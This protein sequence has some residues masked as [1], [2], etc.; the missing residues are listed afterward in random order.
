MHPPRRDG[1]FEHIRNEKQIASVI[2]RRFRSRDETV[3]YRPNP[4]LTPDLLVTARL[5]IKKP[6][7][8]SWSAVI[9]QMALS[10]EEVFETLAGWLYLNTTAEE[11]RKFFWDG[12][13]NYLAHVH[14]ADIWR[15][16]AGA[17]GAACSVLLKEPVY[18]ELRAF[19]EQ[20][21]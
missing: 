10:Y 17:E 15:F 20:P 4:L 21:S 2:C 14:L 6:F 8:Q 3:T 18:S 13:G 19:L 5:V 1:L 7:F 9:P 16:S 11:G 12:A